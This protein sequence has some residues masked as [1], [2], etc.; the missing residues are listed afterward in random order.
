MHGLIFISK[1]DDET[2]VQLNLKE[3]DPDAED[4]I[5]TAQVR[6]IDDTS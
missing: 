4:I 2:A 3:A 1:Y 6:H 5:F